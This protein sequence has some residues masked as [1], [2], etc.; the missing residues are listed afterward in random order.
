MALID[1]LSKSEIMFIKH[2]ISKAKSNM[3]SSEDSTAKQKDLALKKSYQK[4]VERCLEEIEN[5]D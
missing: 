2:A 1:E 4:V 5:E 3:L